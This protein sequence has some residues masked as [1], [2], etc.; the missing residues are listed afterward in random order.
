LAPNPPSLPLGEAV[1]QD[2]RL[3]L[4]NLDPGLRWRNL[5]TGELLAPVQREGECCLAASDVFAH[6]PVALLLSVHGD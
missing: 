1:W 4:S 2:T 5:F 6:F 3:V